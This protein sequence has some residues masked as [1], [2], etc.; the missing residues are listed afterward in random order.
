MI[1][2]GD[3]VTR[4]DYSVGNGDRPI[5]RFGVVT[6]VGAVRAVVLWDNN[7]R[8]YHAKHQ[9][10]RLTPVPENLIVEARRALG[11]SG[12]VIK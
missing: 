2:R 10:S 12:K 8:S 3:L 9:W 1:R 7:R 11:K 6:A 5:R 4:F